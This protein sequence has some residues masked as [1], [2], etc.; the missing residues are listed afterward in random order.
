MCFLMSQPNSDAVRR[1]V[2]ITSAVARSVNQA[3]HETSESVK[4]TPVPG[5]F[6]SRSI[7]SGV[8]PGKNHPHLSSE[9]LLLLSGF[10]L[11]LGQGFLAGVP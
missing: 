4:R 2:H 9:P 8:G 3:Y 1:T 7:A 11:F 10:L 6:W 5:G